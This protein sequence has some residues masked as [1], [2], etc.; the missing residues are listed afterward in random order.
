MVGGRESGHNKKLGFY[1]GWF[2]SIFIA[3]HQQR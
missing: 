2:R 1:I 3:Q